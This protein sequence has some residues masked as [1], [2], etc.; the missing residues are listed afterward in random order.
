MSANM[1]ADR[2]VWTTNDR[3]ALETSS[4]L[5]SASRVDTVEAANKPGSEERDADAEP[6][7]NCEPVVQPNGAEHQNIDPKK[8]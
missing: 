3:S 6:V 2:A 1:K 7:R 5:L 4:R 8:L